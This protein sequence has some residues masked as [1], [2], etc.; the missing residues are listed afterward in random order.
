LLGK[1]AKV[2]D[3]YVQY[4][5]KYAKSQEHVP[6]RQALFQ[7]ALDYYQGAT[8]PSTIETGC[9]IYAQALLEH[10]GL[11]H[12][13]KGYNQPYLMGCH[14]YIFNDPDRVEKMLKDNEADIEVAL[15]SYLKKWGHAD[16]LEKIEDFEL[17]EEFN[18]TM[19][20]PAKTYISEP[21]GFCAMF[22]TT[23]D[24]LEYIMPFLLTEGRYDIKK[25]PQIKRVEVIHSPD[26]VFGMRTTY[27]FPHANRSIETKW[28]G[29]SEVTDSKK[30]ETVDL[31]DDEYIAQMEIQ[32]NQECGW[33]CWTNKDKQ[34]TFGDYRVEY[35][36]DVHHSEKDIRVIALGGGFNECLFFL[37]YYWI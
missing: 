19:R 35:D 16:R 9:L 26:G 8:E 29:S 13:M 30:L 18:D 17:R 12:V 33:K 36:D 23:F 25:I 5:L 22:S 24:D 7:T 6:L 1:T 31:E 28:R 34:H 37:H 27:Y 14:S 2:S 32:R 4:G 21:F 20:N 10:Y 15:R 3:R 11:N